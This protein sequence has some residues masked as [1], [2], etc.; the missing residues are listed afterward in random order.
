[1][2]A[3]TI[4]PG[5]GFGEL[6]PV[7]FS[8]VLEPGPARDLGG[9]EI[10]T[11]QGYAVA[12]DSFTVELGS[13]E[14]LELQGGTGDASFDPA[15]PPPGYGL[16]HGGHCHADDG[17]LVSYADVEAELA[18]GNASFVPIVLLSPPAEVDLLIGSSTTLIPT[19]PML[20]AAS[21]SLLRLNSEGLSLAGRVR[22][23]PADDFSSVFQIDLPLTSGFTAG[24]ELELTRGE[25]PV[26]ELGVHLAPD[27][28]LFDELDFEA[29]SSQ[30]SWTLDNVEGPGADEL[31]AAVGAV[32]PTLVIERSSWSP[33]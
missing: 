11:Q 10:L 13:L 4:S 22:R 32:E 29:L 25:D 16:C 3:C 17:S 2:L 1:M 30:G 23:E 24:L 26:V 15:N 19:D 33:K 14:L 20:P 31:L 5:R 21:L 12:L 8:A 7:S 9:G 18:G 6:Q 28:T 27:G